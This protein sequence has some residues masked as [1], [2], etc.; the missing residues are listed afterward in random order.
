MTMLLNVLLK[1]L[2]LFAVA[3]GACF[4]LR[5]ASAAARHALWLLVLV[6]LCCLPVFC[7]LL[8][9][10]SAPV[11]PA[12][13]RPHVAV[14]TAPPIAAPDPQT[15][16]TVTPTQPTPTPMPTRAE[17]V[18]AASAAN[19]PLAPAI[20]PT[21]SLPRMFPRPTTINWIYGSWL[22][23]AFLVL[24]RTL[25]GLSAASSLIRRCRPITNDALVTAASDA[26]QALGLTR[27]LSL[28]QGD[29]PVPMT[30][31]VRRTVILLPQGASDWPA[32]R[33]RSVLLHEAA[34]VQRWDWA[35]LLFAQC[36]CACYWFHPLVWLAA[37]RLRAEAEAACDDLVLTH[38]IP[39]PDYAAH[40]L[41]I[42]RGLT[43]RRQALTGTL[44]MA[45]WPE[46]SG[47]L[48]T[49]LDGHKPRGRVSRR[50]LTV[51]ALIAVSLLAPLA[52]LRLAAST[53]P[54]QHQVQFTAPP[55]ILTPPGKWSARIQHMPTHAEVTVP[56]FSLS[57]STAG[58]VIENQP[59]ILDIALR[60]NSTDRFIIDGSAFEQ[61][62]FQ[63]TIKDSTGQVVPRT[64][65][66]GRVL[67]PPTAVFAN[68][69]VII[70]TGQTIKYRFNLARLFDMSRTG[71]YEVQ[72]SRSL[73]PQML[74][75]TQEGMM[76]QSITL[77]VPPLRVH[78][79]ANTNASSGPTALAP[80]PA[81]QT[82]LYMASP[83]YPGISR[84]RISGE[85][86]ISFVS[87]PNLPDPPSIIPSSSFGSGPGQLITTPDG[88]TLYAITTNTISQFHIG[89]DGVLSPLPSPTVPTPKSGALLMDPKS[90]YLYNLSSVPYA[91]GTNGQLNLTTI[92]PANV[93][94][95]AG[96]AVDP[97]G[98]FLYS[99]NGFVYG[100]HFG[101]DGQITALPTPSF[102]AA[103]QNGGQAN[104]IALS[105]SG[106]FAYIGVSTQNG[107]AYFDLVVPMRVA[108]N[109]TLAPMPGAHIQVSPPQPV[110]GQMSHACTFLTIDPSG[111]FLF[112][113]DTEGYISSYRIGADGFLFSLGKTS[114]NADLTS[115]YFT[116][117]SN[118]AYAISRNPPVLVPFQMD[119]QH[120]LVPAKVDVPSSIPFDACIASA[121][122][123]TQPIWGPATNGLEMY[124][125]LPADVQ[126]VTSPVVLT[127]VMKNVSA[128]PI[129]LGATGADM[130][131]FRLN[132]T[133][134]QRQSPGILR[135]GGEPATSVVPLLAAGQDLLKTSASDTGS[136]N[137]IELPPGG[138]RQYRL[139]LSQL[140][141]MTVGGNYIIQLDRVLPDETVVAA[142][143]LHLLLTGPFDG[144]IYPDRGF[145]TGQGLAVL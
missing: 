12:V 129:Q 17:N 104:A 25:L 119:F 114:V 76:P 143:V 85:G 107:T 24:G 13:V 48:R 6:A 140:A 64:A 49:I 100:Y 110:V 82:F 10:W 128:K 103:G 52:S 145:M 43:S 65:L 59:A 7:V 69:T 28:L 99:C 121:A 127:V 118:L 142:P 15:L 113:G 9:H 27:P 19:A 137:S 32:D 37:A 1:S 11:L 87:D 116:P 30:C 83:Y 88:H 124:A 109:G 125:H 68:A 134:P 14:S 89:N 97:T 44:A 57:A 33:L 47:R 132:I 3:G 115:L 135:R 55:I 39:A 80:P 84:Y 75:H 95:P 73:R 123:P 101:M 40:L 63:I 105:P 117:T 74:G 26:R 108:A 4:V 38:G 71:D 54:G 18:P 106:Q 93:I 111:R 70:N 23:G 72:V 67:T 92:T 46:V 53:G 50:R 5:R 45:H 138:E 144:I 139:V 20:T 35:T 94:P 34:H 51:A 36:V 131:S 42:V 81:Y 90:R 66:G 96:Y 61:S 56:P 136:Q 102:E 112:V 62:S 41:E 79:V 29:V 98:S 8:P 126:P 77:T 120:G 122:A 22:L 133:G 21:L 130:T 60:N 58:K 16:L 141:D 2:V 91:I 86:N 31:G 78:M